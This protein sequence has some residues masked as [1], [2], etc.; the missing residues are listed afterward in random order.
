MTKEPKSS[1][2]R[3][4]PQRDLMTTFCG[5]KLGDGI[6]N[7]VEY[8]KLEDRTYN[9]L[10]REGIDSVDKLVSMPLANLIELKGMGKDSLIDLI[11]KVT[12][13]K[14]AKY[15]RKFVSKDAEN[16]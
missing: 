6:R 8:L 4:R 7:Q 13:Y 1:T 11:E 5:I 10:V 9:I 12:A 3:K 15:Q 2:T 14:Y 16:R